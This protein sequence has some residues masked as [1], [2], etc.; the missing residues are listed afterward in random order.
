[1]SDH[2]EVDWAGNTL[3]IWINKRHTEVQETES[4]GR[5]LLKPVLDPQD[6]RASHPPIVGVRVYNVDSEDW[7]WEKLSRSLASA[8][9]IGGIGSPIWAA[10]KRCKSGL[11]SR[12]YEAQYSRPIPC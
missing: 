8:I 4:N 7:S 1:M 3:T 12:K 11:M 2:Y 9:G 6:K 5:M 10:A